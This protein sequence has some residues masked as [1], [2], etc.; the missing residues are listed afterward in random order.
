MGL[1][2]SGGGGDSHLEL[3]VVGDSSQLFQRSEENLSCNSCSLN[4]VTHF[5]GI[6]TFTSI[7][8][9][10]WHSQTLMGCAVLPTYT[11]F[12]YLYT[13]TKNG[14]TKFVDHIQAFVYMKWNSIF[15]WNFNSFLKY[16]VSKIIIRIYTLLYNCGQVFIFS[17][18][19]T[20]KNDNI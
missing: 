1:L 11:H 8:W 6:R 3:V 14:N 7:C 20:K 4:F 17:Y 2:G 13:P 12:V 5:W 19:V 16:W 9:R 15:Y 10:D 18:C